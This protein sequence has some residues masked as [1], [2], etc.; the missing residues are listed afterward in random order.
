MKRWVK[1]TVGAGV[2]LLVLVAGT[3]VVGTT[4]AEKKG[5]RLVTVNVRPVSFPTD[6]QS[7]ER[8]KY[9]FSSRGCVDCHGANG[10]GREFVNDGRGLRL[11]GPNI[12]PG[13]GKVVARYTPEDWVRAVRQG[14]KP[15]GRPLFVMPSEDYNRFTDADLGAL[16]AYVRSLPP[17]PGGAAVLE[18]SL[19]VRLMYGFGGIQDAAEKIDHSLPPATAV[20]EGVTA[21]HGAYV[22]NMCISCHGPGLSGGKIPGTPPDWAPAANLTPGDGNAMTR[23][24]DAGAFVAM[25]RS[26][27]RPDGTTVTVMPFESLREINEVDAQ[28]LYVY[29]KTVPARP[30]GQR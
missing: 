7:L 29:L 5:E 9:L 28:A 2:T 21:A 22:A 3:A 13:E 27:K 4:L 24:K 16:V 25:L 18:L 1:W 17:Q 8:G 20:A 30:F 15:D 12:T 6:A 11:A 10:G 14:V 23:Y 19:P 26:G